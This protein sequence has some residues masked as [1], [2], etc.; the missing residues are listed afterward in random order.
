MAGELR[1]AG[2]SLGEM[3]PTLDRLA[4]ISFGLS[5]SAGHDR[6][7][8]QEI[9]SFLLVVF[10]YH[11]G[12]PKTPESTRAIRTAMER[13]QIVYYS[14]TGYQREAADP[15]LEVIHFVQRL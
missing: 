8:A 9:T 4:N 1:P 14:K 2:V 7:K 10:M 3:Q 13:G 11:F 5:W 15:N 6:T 12:I